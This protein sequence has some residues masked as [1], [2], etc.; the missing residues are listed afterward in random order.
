MI[1]EVWLQTEH[2]EEA[3][4]YVGRKSKR[5]LEQENVSFLNLNKKQLTS[6]SVSAILHLT[7]QRVKALKIKVLKN[8]KGVL[9]TERK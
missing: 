4:R 5:G 8:T 7:L 9:V 2:L 3:Y 1:Q 6:T